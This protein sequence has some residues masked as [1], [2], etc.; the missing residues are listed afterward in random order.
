MKITIDLSGDLVMHSNRAREALESLTI[1]GYRTA[2]LSHFEAR[3]MLEMAS[4]E[5]DDFLQGRHVCD[6]TIDPED[7][8]LD[9]EALMQLQSEPPAP[10]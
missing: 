5:F 9:L 7:L 4:L 6:Q 3:R 8:V 10:K 1:E 2:M